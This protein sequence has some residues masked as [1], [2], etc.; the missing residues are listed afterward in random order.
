[1]TASSVFESTFAESSAALARRAVQM[2]AAKNVICPRVVRGTAFL[3]MEHPFIISLWSEDQ[4]QRSSNFYANERTAQ[5]STLW[6]DYACGAR[7][8]CSKLERL[9]GDIPDE[10]A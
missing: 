9:R 10:V 3:C 5:P 8:T 4:L 2:A 7:A 6:A 1:V